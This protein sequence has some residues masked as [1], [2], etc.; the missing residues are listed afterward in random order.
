ML[1]NEI[2]CCYIHSI[3]FKTCI[4]APSSLPCQITLLVPCPL[5]KSDPFGLERQKKPE[6]RAGRLILLTF[7]FS[8]QCDT[9]HHMEEMTLTIYRL[10]GHFITTTLPQGRAAP[11]HLPKHQSKT[12]KSLLSFS[13]LFFS[14]L[15][16]IEKG[17]SNHS[18]LVKEIVEALN[19]VTNC[20][21]LQQIGYLES[22][23]FCCFLP[24]MYSTLPLSHRHVRAHTHTHTHF[25]LCQGTAAR[26]I[27]T[28]TNGFWLLL[29]NPSILTW[30]DMLSKIQTLELSH[31]LFMWHRW[32]VAIRSQAMGL[33]DLRC[34]TV[35]SGNFEKQ[36]PEMGGKNPYWKCKFEVSQSVCLS[37]VRIKISLSLYVKVMCVCTGCVEL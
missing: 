12:L 1:L 14:P 6:Q 11:F 15:L 36:Y 35:A 27:L 31:Q 9:L 16:T 3:C 34:C 25:P 8:L 4:S 32:R 7:P 21:L 22:P 17:E 30:V 13:C 24:P 19:T 37:V 20:S 33:G 2:H 29:G 23:P 10:T 28:N 5:W 18:K 26:Q